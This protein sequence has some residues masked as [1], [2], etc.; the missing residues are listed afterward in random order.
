METVKLIG[1]IL[2][3]LFL[4]PQLPAADWPTYR[5]NSQRQGYSPEVLADKLELQW[6]RSA[7]QKPQPAW[8]KRARQQHD[9]E[10]RM[11]RR[12]QFDMV[13]QPIVVNQ[14]VYYGSS[15]DDSVTALNSEGQLLWRFITGGPVRTAVLYHEG[16]IYAGSDDGFMYCLDAVSGRL[17]WKFFA[18][19]EKQSWVMGNGRLVS[20]WAIRGGAAVDGETLYFGAGVWPD[21]KTYVIALDLKNGRLKWRS[22]SEE[23]DAGKKNSLLKMVSEGHLVLSDKMVISP[24]GRISSYYFNRKDGS[25]I[26]GDVD[27]RGYGTPTLV[28]GVI[29]HRDQLYYNSMARLLNGEGIHGQGAGGH[30]CANEEMIFSI[31]GR[32]ERFM[33]SGQP[34]HEKPL[35]EEKIDRKGNKVKVRKL[36][37]VSYRLK[38]GASNTRNIFEI[39]CSKNKIFVAHDSQISVVEIKTKKVR[40]LPLDSPAWALAISNGRL[41]A[42]TE[43]GALYCFG[44][45]RQEKLVRETGELRTNQF[46]DNAVKEIIAKSQRDKGYCIILD[47]VKGELTRSLLQQSDYQILLL[48]K[49]SDEVSRLRREL[50]RTGHYGT[51]VAVQKADDLGRL[52]WHADLLLSAASLRG[53]SVDKAVIKRWLSPYLGVAVFGTPGKMLVTKADGIEGAGNWSHF[54]ADSGNTFNSNDRTIKGR[55]RI[56]W[57]NDTLIA[58]A[59]RHARP[60]V[61]VV[62]DGVMVTGGLDEM[63]ACNVYNGK[64]LWTFQVK[65][66]MTDFD[67]W[68]AGGATMGSIYC[69]G[70]GYVFV[71]AGSECH[72]LDILRGDKI[73]TFK[74]PRSPQGKSD[75]WGHLSYNNGRLFG[76]VIDTEHRIFG[77]HGKGVKVKL[78]GLYAE[79]GWPLLLTSKLRSCSGNG[80]RRIHCTITA[81][82]PIHSTSTCWIA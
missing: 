43:S 30:I 52:R 8:F 27:S 24:A 33:L 1:I 32:D 61:C 10:Y 12:Y 41:Y 57:Y 7:L 69:A 39:V 59:N 47:D 62:V 40:V 2:S 3:L 9:L 60:Q 71:R 34:R 13:C 15:A 82:L 75:P 35:L 25:F 21:D 49:S 36:S 50:H 11:L 4:A 56:R 16:F 31:S 66:L 14:T 29:Y 58:M 23:G 20:R 44:A 46:Y 80:R 68:G 76:S 19:E 67:H 28:D 64:V 53:Q 65:N 70:D 6:R 77:S 78:N 72:M 38:L 55:Q 48:A 63:V 5:G 45:E 51:R 81:W 26:R 17:K 42:G 79:S 37:K 22:S 73:H 54:Y 74:T 18:G